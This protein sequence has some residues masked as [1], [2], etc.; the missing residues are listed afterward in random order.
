M[1]FTYRRGEAYKRTTLAKM[2]GTITLSSIRSV[3]RARVIAET[4]PGNPKRVEELAPV[5][6]VLMSCVNRSVHVNTDHA[7]LDTDLDDLSE[8]R[9]ELVRGLSLHLVGAESLERG[10]S[11]FQRGLDLVEERGEGA[12]ASLFVGDEGV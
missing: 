10:R 12:R 5:A 1:Y 3:S 8:Q 9:R 2:P 6:E 11:R 7:R 4:M